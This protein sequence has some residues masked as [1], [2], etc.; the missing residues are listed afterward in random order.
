MEV[1]FICPLQTAKVHNGAAE[2][3]LLNEAFCYFK[4]S[5][6]VM[7]YAPIGPPENQ[8]RLKIIQPQSNFFRR[9]QGRIEVESF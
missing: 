5:N 9:V 4:I 8:W 6:Y 7:V 3:I 2:I 1:E